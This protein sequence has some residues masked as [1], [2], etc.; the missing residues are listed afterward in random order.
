M[1]EN[2]QISIRVKDKFRVLKYTLQ[3]LTFL[4]KQQLKNM[5]QSITIKN[6]GYLNLRDSQDQKYELQNIS[7]NKNGSVQPFCTPTFFFFNPY[8]NS[9]SVSSV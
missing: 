3:E 2:T 5:R 9:N 8:W 1:T 6:T 7:I 4:L